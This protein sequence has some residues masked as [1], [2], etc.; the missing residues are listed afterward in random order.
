MTEQKTEKRNERIN[1]SLTPKEADFLRD[2]AKK[3]KIPIVGLIWTAVN[4]YKQN[5]GKLEMTD[6]LFTIE[7]K[8]ESQLK[9]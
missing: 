1:I 6:N 2:F 9:Q 7:E 3:E 8:K 5:K 4:F